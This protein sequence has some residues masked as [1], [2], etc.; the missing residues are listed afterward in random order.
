MIRDHMRI[1]LLRPGSTLE[2]FG[3][4]PSW[5]DETDVRDAVNQLG[6]RWR[7]IDEEGFNMERSALHGNGAHEVLGA[8]HL[9]HEL[10]MVFE[11]EPVAVV[12]S[13]KSF[14]VSRIDL[15]VECRP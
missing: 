14:E 15:Q 6:E 3:E 10:V 11:D 7:P 8:I 12:Q 4:L 5:L 2:Q 9:R 1:W 13:D